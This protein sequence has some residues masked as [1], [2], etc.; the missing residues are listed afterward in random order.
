MQSWIDEK[1]ETDISNQDLDEHKH[2]NRS[3]NENSYLS[4]Y[5]G[6]EIQI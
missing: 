6:L 5:Y 4:N 3:P 1:L 2:A